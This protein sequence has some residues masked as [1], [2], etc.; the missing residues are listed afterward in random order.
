M[1]ILL[2]ADL[3]LLRTTHDHTLSKIREWV[4][5]VHPDALVVAGDLSSA[6]QAEETLRLLRECFPS[7]PMAICLGNHD[8][9]VH[10]AV[11]QECD[12]L[13]DVIDR[14]WEPAAKAFD[15]V[16]LD[17]E[18]LSLSGLT[19]VGG[20]GHYDFGF[21]VP[22]LAYDGIAVTEEDYLRGAPPSGSA[23]RWSDFRFMP[24]GRHPR[25]IATEQVAG[26]RQRLAEVSGSQAIVVLHTPPF[27]V[28]LGVPP[29]T[30]Y[31]LHATPSVYAFF[32]AYLGNRAMGDLLREACDKVAAVVCGHT[33][34]AAGPVYL[35]GTVTVGIN[36]GGDYGIPRAVLYRTD[37][38]EFERLA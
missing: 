27:E 22:G 8:F 21:A 13:P 23:M 7:G 34:R 26:V 1:K 14:F 25:E 28:L 32:R 30:E 29:L 12:S 3:H 35:N 18:N 2:T 6:Q 24:N 17:N 38:M 9:W 10:D 33:H 36:V 20:Y 15:V 16:L 19:I 11:L 37:S 5:G 4:T 31:R